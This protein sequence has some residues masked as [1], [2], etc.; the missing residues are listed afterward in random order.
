MSIWP[1]AAT[2]IKGDGPRRMADEMP[3]RSGLNPAPPCACEGLS[4]RLFMRERLVTRP[5]LTR[6][7]LDA[8][9]APAA[10]SK[11][12]DPPRPR[13]HFLRAELDVRY[14]AFLVTTVGCGLRPEE[15]CRLHRS[16][17]DREKMQLHVR[18]RFTHGVVKAGSK[19][20][21][22]RIIPFGQRV[23]AALDAMPPRIDTPILFPAPRGGYIDMRSSGTGSGLPRSARRGSSITGS[24]ICDIRTSPGRCRATSR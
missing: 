7:A 6:S 21:A 5:S 11:R 14:R 3:I 8:E 18:R 24:T 19:T 4:V 10:V 13:V 23:L 15:A 2:W 17:V 1:S 12:H 16:D 22:G 9:T 20:D